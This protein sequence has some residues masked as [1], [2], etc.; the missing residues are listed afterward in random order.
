[1][2]VRNSSMLAALIGLVACGGGGGGAVAKSSGDSTFKSLASEIIQDNYRRHPS[3]ATLLGVH[4]YDNQL[5]DYS[6]A[7]F[8]AEAKADSA[9]KA[10]LARR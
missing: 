2:F 8:E 1:M 10:R 6:A 3:A 9:F 4:T 7:A 5:E